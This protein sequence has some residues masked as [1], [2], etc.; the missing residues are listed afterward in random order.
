MI[1]TLWRATDPLFRHAGLDLDHDWPDVVAPP[2]QTSRPN[3]NLPPAVAATMTT[4]SP[5]EAPV[6]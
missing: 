6:L 4:R 5:T 1:R 2:R 3:R